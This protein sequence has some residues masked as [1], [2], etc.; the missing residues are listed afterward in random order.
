MVAPLPAGDFEFL[1]VDN[2]GN[3]ILLNSDVSPT[4]AFVDVTEVTGL[5][6]SP[7]RETFRDHE[8]AEGGFLDAEFEK[9]R[10]ILITGVVYSPT[11]QLETFLDQLK[12]NYAPRVSHN[13]LYFSTPGVGVRF[14]NCKS[15]GVRYDWDT[16]RRTGT[17]RVQFGLYA[18]DPRFYS[19]PSL[20]TSLGYQTGPSGGFG[21]NFGFNFGFG[22]PPATLYDQVHAYNDGNRPAPVTVTINGPGVNPRILNE[23]NAGELLL[24]MTLVT[25]DV[26]VIDMLNHTVMLN[27]T[28]NRR[29]AVAVANWF[30][31]SPGDNIVRFQL[32]GGSGTVGV[33][34][35]TL[36]WTGAWR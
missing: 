9:G 19:Y 15:R 3:G 20:T 10:D 2:N 28:A 13:R 32:A 31:L 12:E 21:F 4:Q 25:G 24:N 26:L 6:N 18:E 36:A 29:D 33:S 8:G 7:F 17:L 5:D 27:G 1:F 34:Q 35:M 11:S 16:F 23:T 22:T 30:L 14:I